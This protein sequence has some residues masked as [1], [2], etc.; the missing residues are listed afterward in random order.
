LR[1]L[2]KA[3]KE[4]TKCLSE[5]AFKSEAFRGYDENYMKSFRS[6]YRVT[7]EF[8]SNN[9]TYII[10]DDEIILGFYSFV[11]NDRTASL[12]YFYIEPS[13]IGHGYGKLLWNHMINTC[14]KMGLE[15]VE[16]VTS[17]QAE[18]FIPKENG[19]LQFF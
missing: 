14:K 6:N 11:I 4:E 1:S 15:K 18:K 12:E 9:P 16:L 3:K 2:R 5:I 17:P 8:I 7:E 10:E 19:A 13:S